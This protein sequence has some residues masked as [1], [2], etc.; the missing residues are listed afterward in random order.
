MISKNDRSPKLTRGAALLAMALASVFWSGCAVTTEPP[1]GEVSGTDTSAIPPTDQA[2]P[3]TTRRTV[4]LIPDLALED[5]DRGAGS[6]AFPG[7]DAQPP[8]D[9]RG[10]GNTVSLLQRTAA[11]LGEEVAAL[12]RDIE[13]QRVGL[14]QLRVEHRY[15]QDEIQATQDE[16][17][18]AELQRQLAVKQ[19]GSQTASE[20]FEK[21][22]GK[23]V[24]R[25]ALR[26]R[27]QWSLV[28]ELERQVGT[29]DGK[30][31][32]QRLT[33]RD[34]RIA[35][36]Y[37]Q[38]ELAKS[39]DETRRAELARQLKLK[40]DESA[41]ASVE[42]QRVEAERNAKKSELDAAREAAARYDRTGA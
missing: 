1:A 16:T 9:L 33:L 35:W 34:L 24:E 23:L 6:G 41:R 25:K 18:R 3:L 2:A 17:R 28:N 5:G 38:E 15:L 8:E 4:A 7:P 29:L 26:A 11:S 30:L 40:E 22:E 13:E 27:A 36:R 14:R 12:E 39:S 32:Q 21:T 42:F 19:T 31:D 37:T 10:G 20:R